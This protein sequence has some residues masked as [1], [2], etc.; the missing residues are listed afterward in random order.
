VRDVVGDVHETLGDVV[1]SEKR[2]KE[3]LLIGLVRWLSEVE[4]GSYRC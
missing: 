3:E 4:V 1:V 2:V